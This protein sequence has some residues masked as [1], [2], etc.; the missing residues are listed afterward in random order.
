MD[1][2]ALNEIACAFIPVRVFLVGTLDDHRACNQRSILKEG[3]PVNI[4]NIHR[5]V[6]RTPA[7]SR[8]IDDAERVEYKNALTHGRP[9]LCG[10]S[11][12]FTLR[13]GRQ[14]AAPIEQHIADET[15][16]LSGS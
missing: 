4:E 11:C 3:R 16:G 7:R 6:R 9:T 12:Q 14:N 8:L 10:Q 2:D 13:I 15:H 5:V 1:D